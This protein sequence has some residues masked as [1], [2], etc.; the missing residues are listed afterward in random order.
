MGSC[1]TKQA[2]L[3]PLSWA[4]MACNF[5]CCPSATAAADSMAAAASRASV[6]RVAI[7]IRADTE[8]FR[9]LVI[10]TGIC[11]S[12]L[13]V[14][15]GLGYEL[16]M[17][18]DGSIFSYSIA[19][20]D[21]WAFH[22]HNISGR[23]VVYLFSH[24]PAETYVEL[25]RDA[26]GGIVV[27]GFLFFVAP[28]LGLIGTF[29]ADRTKGRT[30]FSYACF[31][32][33]CVCPLVFGFPTEMWV[34]HALFWPTLAVCHY[35][36]SNIG[37][38]A[39]VFAMLLALVFTHEATLIFAMTILATLLLRGMRDAAF[40]RGVGAFLVVMSIWIV[41]KRTLPPDDYIADVL[42]Q[43]ALHIFD[44]TILT[45]DLVL[46]LFGA[47]AIYTI[48]FL[49]LRRL[50]PAKAHVYAASIIA[51]VLAVYWLWFDNA[52]HTDNRYYLR[53]ALIVAT[54]VF[55]ALAAL[56][57]LAAEG[58]LVLPVPF[59]P[60]VMAAFTSGLTGRAAA[61]AILLVML[62]HA[63]E[64]AKFVTA[65]MHYKAAVRALAMGA[66]SDPTLGDPHFVSSRRIGA[67][68]NRLS[69]SSTT[70]YL[71][72]LVAPNFA[73]ARLIV[74]PMVNFFWLSCQTATANLESD[75]VVPAESRR[76]VQR[77]SCLHR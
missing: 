9:T 18:A 21:A 55:G 52:L 12:V 5:H 2:L 77:D 34:A 6:K 7:T 11:G 54:P 68:L 58:R 51:V 26:H 67:N 13:F 19:V 65:W 56:H 61:G 41:V 73:P 63:V 74:D 10:T 16:Q 49:V 57:A 14:V 64:T 75:R 60:R 45:G 30:I 50:R 70:Q 72:V 31:S 40:L 1:A 38:I 8:V 20:Q 27:Y 22:W 66:A 47:L 43:A 25:T 53:T 3:R 42:V 32:T 62:V 15:I 76:L 37:G 35:V 23:V 29:A 4:A 24:V 59:L 17:Y 33:A 46:L 36:R 44:S 28:L 69:W 48:A 71:S 39:C